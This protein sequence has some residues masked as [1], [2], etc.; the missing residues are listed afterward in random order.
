MEPVNIKDTLKV[1][2]KKL[3]GFESV[4]ILELDGYLD[5]YNSKNFR[6]YVQDIV[7]E[8]YK[9]IIINCEKLTYVSSTGIG[10]FTSFNRMLIQKGGE[11]I[12]INMIPK[13]YEVFK[14]LGFLSFFKI[15]SSLDEAK[16]FL[17]GG[18]STTTTATT[19]SPTGTNVF[20][21]QADC[22]HC[23][24]KL[25]FSKAGKFRCPNCQNIIVVTE[26]GD[27]EKG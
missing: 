14:L 23:G 21:I 25:K 16:Q 8:G 9:Y 4:A 1:N 15:F 18:V 7:N 20:P 24:K 13:V 12:L 26:K 17:S 27:V 5:T 3:E 19:T 22:P 11:L 6:Q 10:S 2:P